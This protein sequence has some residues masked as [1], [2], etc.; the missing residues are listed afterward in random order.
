MKTLNNENPNRLFLALEFIALCAVLPSVIIYFRLAPYMFA[1][2]WG[3]ASYGLWIL[4]R[5]MGEDRAAWLELWGWDA[6]HWK[7]LRPILIRWVL[8]CAGMVLF[9][10]LI[11]PDRLFQ[12]FLAKPYFVLLLFVFY[13]IFSALP[14]EF[15]FCSFFFRRYAPFFQTDRAKIIASSITF[16]YAHVLFINWVAPLLSLIAG[17]IF[18]QTY[19][20]SR[21]LALVTI[22]HGL[23]GNFLFMVGLGW[24]FFGG[25]VGAH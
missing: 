11:D 22:E 13:P 21:S 8:C 5:K 23:Y 12:M 9:T 3:A 25:A 15:I 20:K 24:Y 19:A 16:A 1:F 2:L 6:V 7:N 18:A 10:Y 17:V 14:Q 4:W